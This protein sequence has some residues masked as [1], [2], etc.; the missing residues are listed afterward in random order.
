MTVVKEVVTNFLM[1]DGKILIVK[2]S[3]QVSTY[4]G[5][6]AGISGY[7]E[8][9]DQSSLDRAIIEIEEETGLNRSEI[10]LIKKGEPLR[11]E[12]SEND[13]IWIVHPFLWEIPSKDVK[14][15]W[16]NV[17]LKWIE[18]EEIKNFETVPNLKET[19]DRVLK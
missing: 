18:P 11:I 9:S 17:E 12:D 6:W 8:T 7:I 4:Q 10:K 14:L 2:R 5:R 1:H 15:D 13:R 19:L 16:E 3:S